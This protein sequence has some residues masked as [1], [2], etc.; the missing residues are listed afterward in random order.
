MAEP[1]FQIAALEGCDA[2]HR[3]RNK[4]THRTHLPAAKMLTVSRV[5][6]GGALEITAM[7]A[8]FPALSQ[9][10]HRKLLEVA[11]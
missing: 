11:Q 10:A 3:A 1:I 5:R 2:S 7:R 4:D 8:G 6:S 9:S